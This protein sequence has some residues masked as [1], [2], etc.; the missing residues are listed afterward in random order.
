VSD[1]NKSL[2]SMSEIPKDWKKAIEDLKDISSKWPSDLQSLKA[3]LESVIHNW[4]HLK[5]ELK[6]EGMDTPIR[7]TELNWITG[8]IS[9]TL[10]KGTKIDKIEIEKIN[11]EAIKIAREELKERITHLRELIELLINAISPGGTLKSTLDLIK[12]SVE[13][14]PE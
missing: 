7:K 5:I 6:I 10:P 13:K 8:S 12:T 1:I 2:I 4:T 3:D 9:V 11:S 14:L